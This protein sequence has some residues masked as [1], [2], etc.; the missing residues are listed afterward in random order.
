[1]SEEMLKHTLESLPTVV[2]TLQKD[3]T[4]RQTELQDLK[5][6]QKFTNPDELKGVVKEMLHNLQERVT[7]YLDGDLFS[8]M[9]FKDKLQTLADELDEEEESPWSLQELSFHTGKEDK[10]RN[11]IADMEEYPEEIQPD[12]HY[13][14][15]KQVHR[16]IEFFRSVMIDSLPN[17]Y[18]LAE[19]VPIAAGY[20]GGGLMRENWEGATKQICKVLM[21]NVTH[22]GKAALLLH[23]GCH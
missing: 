9:K 23:D 7:A 17:P 1:M 15:G 18:E 16:A 8:A 14:G 4:T 5:E 19:L 20:G 10:W 12:K 11:H 13:L 22:P 21:Q 6:K 3:L 2:A